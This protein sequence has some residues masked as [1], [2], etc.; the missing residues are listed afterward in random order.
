MLLPVRLCRGDAAE[1]REVGEAPV[2][3]ARPR[4]VARLAMLLA[5]DVGG[6][7]PQSAPLPSQEFTEPDKEKARILS[8]PTGSS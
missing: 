7:A 5:A 1:P 6:P 2:N 4:Q 8:R 3:E